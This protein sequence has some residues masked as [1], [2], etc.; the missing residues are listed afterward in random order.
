MFAY[1]HIENVYFVEYLNVYMCGSPTPVTATK[2]DIASINPDC[3]LLIHMGIIFSTASNINVRYRYKNLTQQL[4][5]RVLYLTAKYK[6]QFILFLLNY[7]PLNVVR[8]LTM[9]YHSFRTCN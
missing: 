6:C 5:I 2:T 4:C 1:K 3:I 9:T 8:V 7:I